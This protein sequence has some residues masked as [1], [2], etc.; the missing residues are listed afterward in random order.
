MTADVAA[1]LADWKN[2]SEESEAERD[3]LVREAKTGGMN[4]RQIAILSGL[5]RTTIYKILSGEGAA[6]D[7]R[8][9]KRRDQ[10]GAGTL[11]EITIWR[12][13]EAIWSDSLKHKAAVEA[14]EGMGVTDAEA[15]IYNAMQSSHAYEF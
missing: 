15:V 4:I 1:R 8:T 9:I 2:R 12:G 3:Q 11:F 10:A 7:R 13:N 6:M 5:S 14:M